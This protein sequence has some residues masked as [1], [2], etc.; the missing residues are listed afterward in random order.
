MDLTAE[1]MASGILFAHSLFTQGRYEESRIM[2][3]GLLTLDP[4]NAYMHYLLGSTFSL[5]DRLKEAL[6]AY[7]RSIELFPA[8]VSALVNRGEIYLKLGDFQRAAA[9]LGKAVEMDPQAKDSSAHRA[10]F[11]LQMASGALRLAEEK[12]VDA[13]AEIQE[14]IKKQIGDG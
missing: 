12:G 9:D 8:Y 3:E 5:Q 4:D 11:L 14:Q 2:L 13:V 10:R 6:E 1:E 7:S